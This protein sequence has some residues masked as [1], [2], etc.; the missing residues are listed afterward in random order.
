MHLNN[1]S[2]TRKIS[3]RLL[4]IFKGDHNDSIHEV[5]EIPPRQFKVS[6]INTCLPN[7]SNTVIK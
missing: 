1:F 4:R 3:T 6:W 5:E 7:P 2:S